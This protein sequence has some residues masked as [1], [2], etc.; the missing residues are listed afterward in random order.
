MDNK[1]QF[2]RPRPNFPKRAVVTGGMPY[3]N[4]ELHFAHF[5]GYMVHADTFARFLRDR[6]GEENVVF[7]SGTDCYGSPAVE[8]FRKLKAEGKIN[9]DRIEDFVK[10][11]HEKQKQTYLNFEIEHN[12]FGASALEP[13]ASVH[14]D[15][16]KHFIETLYKNGTVSLMGSLQF[17][18]EEHK[19]LLN[20]RQVIGKCPI[21]NCQSEKGY[22]D[23]CDLGHQYSPMEL[24]DPV[25]TL[26]GQK[27]KLVEVK[28]WYFNLQNY[29]PALTE[30]SETIAKDKATRQFMIK[31]INEFFKAPEIYIK[32]DQLDKFNEI[33]S[34]LP[35]FEDITPNPK[36]PS[37]TFVFEKLT[38]REEACKILLDNGIKFR[39][40]K[41]LVPF[42]LTG[43]IDWGVN[44]PE[45]ECVNGQTFYV[46]PESLWAPISF[47][48]T[49]LMSKGKDENEWRK[50]WASSDAE[51]YQFIG[52]DNLYFYGPAQQAMWL[53]MNGKDKISYEDG[54]L[55]PTNIIPSKHVLFLNK[56]ASSSGS[57]KP[58]MANELLNYYTAE[59]LRMHFLGMNL[60][61]NNV[62]F[63]PKP[64]NPDAKPEEVDVVLKEGNLLTNVYNRVLRTLFYTTQQYY[65]G[66]VP[67][68]EIDQGV[69]EELK[70]HIL[71][72]ERFMAERKFH[73]VINVVD[74]LVRNINK[75]WVK[76]IKEVGDNKEKL[77]N[78]IAT[79]F[80]QIRVANVLLH[81]IA[82]Y[83]T[84]NV[85]T[86]LGLKENWNS[87]EY[88]FD[89]VYSLLESKDNHK[90]K[91]LKE[92]E[93]FF[94]K[95]P[96]Q[97]DFE[98]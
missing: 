45:I 77:N 5:G 10:S 47:T 93:D 24:I 34:N 27:P 88:I 94:K 46:W 87:W 55:K 49:Y 7:V 89:D 25:S 91:T 38:D 41:T 51:V 74:V 96:S 36:A 78:L 18:D 84:E 29:I 21:E 14:A 82:P 98:N 12:L 22:A 64:F 42:R 58:P 75:Y 20:G 72:Y 60:G 53:C 16:S 31:E 90:L 83:G 13:S 69:K 19:C 52:E 8:S 59:Q 66:V 71:N 11:N 61:N 33:A 4:K 37:S 32:K 44:C 85:A 68:G 26:S 50:F 30:W 95:H 73:Q 28:N 62:S 54:D 15:M 6:I 17:Y 86:Y 65:D 35:K 40:G 3:G 48:K 92:K 67:V 2:E 1:V 70:N 63:M 80:E 76:E 23:E 39:T 9:F 43:D 97:L 57:F 81:P 56:K 79:T